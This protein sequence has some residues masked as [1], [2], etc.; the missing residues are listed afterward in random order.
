MVNAVEDLV[1]QAAPA[2]ETAIPMLSQLLEAEIAERE[3]RSIAYTPR[4]HASPHIKT[5][6]ALILRSAKSTRRR[7]HRCEFIEAVENVVLISGPGTGKSHTATTIGFQA[8]EHHRR[9][10]RFFSTVELVNAFEQ[11]KALG[12]ACN[13]AQMLTKVDLVILDE[14]GCLPFSSSGGALLFHLLSKLNERNSVII[15]TNLGFSK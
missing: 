2:F 11:E 7:L 15:T 4:W 8:I 1:A 3:M 9:K 5:S 14:L 6:P 12:K 13:I 10:V